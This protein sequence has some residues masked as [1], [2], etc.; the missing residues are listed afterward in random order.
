MKLKLSPNVIFVLFCTGIHSMSPVP[1]I[2]P[3]PTTPPA[4]RRLSST[5]T[6]GGYGTSTSTSDE[7]VTSSPVRASSPSTNLDSQVR[8][9]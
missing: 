6:D 2:S 4:L 9:L 8:C 5:S 3:L 7:E 1:M